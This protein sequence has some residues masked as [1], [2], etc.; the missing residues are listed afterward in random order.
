MTTLRKP[1]WLA[2][3]G[4]LCALLAGASHAL[5]AEQA[6][7]MA[8]AD[9]AEQRVSAINQAVLA[10]DANSDAGRLA[11]YLQA[12]ANDEVKVAGGKAFVLSG[13]TTTDPATGSP[14]H[15][16]AGAE[17][18]VNNNYLRGV[19]ESAQ[20]ALVLGDPSSDVAARR[21]AAEQLAAE[22]D[23]E[24]LPLVEKALAAEKD[25]AIK[26]L[27]ERTKAAS[28]LGSAD[29]AQRLAAVELLAHQQ[30]PET[31][32][33]LNQRLSDETDPAVQKAL[34][35]A[36][37]NIADGLAWGQRLG[38]IF[39]AISPRCALLLAPLRFAIT[40]GLMGVI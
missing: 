16:P 39:S 27:L 14:A 7:Q 28:L 33:L 34:K 30:T 13:N 21:K 18:I 15:M 23:A 11:A 20:A 5:T 40:Y 25:D 32:L 29:A 38:A 22:P 10:P 37:A 9:D 2:T 19:I 35:A 1:F 4:S 36:L 31:Q 26:Q 12:L 3:V 24:R 17:D 8:G 6:F